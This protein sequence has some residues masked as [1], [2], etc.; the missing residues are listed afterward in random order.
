MNRKFGFLFMG[1]PNFEQERRGERYGKFGFPFMGIPNFDQ[2]R[3]EKSFSA[4]DFFKGRFC[5]WC[6]G[7]PS[8]MTVLMYQNRDA[9]S[10]LKRC[11]KSCRLRWLN[12]LRPDIKLGG[13]TE[14]E[15]DIISSLYISIGSR[16][17]VIASHLHGRT[18][19]DVKNHWN[20]KLKKRF[21]SSQSQN[22]TNTTTTTNSVVP[23]INPMQFSSPVFLPKQEV[24]EQYQIINN[25]ILD[26]SMTT[27]DYNQTMISSSSS[28]SFTDS[29][30]SFQENQGLSSNAFQLRND[31]ADW[32]S[33][34]DGGLTGSTD[35]ILNEGFDFRQV[36]GEVAN[37]NYPSSQW[38]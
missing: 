21:S 37:F 24:L 38:F 9:D 17:S 23:C 28:N 34:N 31:Y 18:D 35:D 7:G 14:E 22:T 29:I 26:Y 12:Y 20:T 32:C 6:R 15:D 4:D 11:G 1:I 16:W 36:L 25:P 3:R 10:R 8:Y 2:E 27:V 19:N 30:S 33:I 13:F 5:G